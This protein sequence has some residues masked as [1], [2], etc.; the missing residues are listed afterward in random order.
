MRFAMN[1]R[2]FCKIFIGLMVACLLCVILIPTV[3]TSDA[4][5]SFFIALTIGIGIN[6]L[7][8]LLRNHQMLVFFTQHGLLRKLIKFYILCA[9]LI[10]VIGIPFF[11]ASIR[12]HPF[13]KDA[14]HLMEESNVVKNDL[15]IPL[16]VDWPIEGNLSET[17]DSGNSILEIPVSGSHSRGTLRVEATKTNALW[18]IDKLKLIPRDSDTQEL[19]IM[20]GAAGGPGTTNPK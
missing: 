1:E 5:W 2:V 3:R 10:F 15:G 14:V 20:D 13:F 18:K 9:P 17:P 7:Y 12:R 11:D 8:L 4:A 16:K 19:L 6:L